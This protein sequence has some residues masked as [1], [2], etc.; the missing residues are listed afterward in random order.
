M[1]HPHRSDGK[2]RDARGHYRQARALK[3]SAADLHYVL[4]R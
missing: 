1:R 2:P 4:N 3:R